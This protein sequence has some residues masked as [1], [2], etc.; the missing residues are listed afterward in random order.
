MIFIL[1]LFLSKG[2]KLSKTLVSGFVGTVSVHS[3]HAGVRLCTFGSPLVCGEG[4]IESF[5][6]GSNGD[7]LHVI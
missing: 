4:S 5:S 7:I 2:F 6:Q 1:F 3:L